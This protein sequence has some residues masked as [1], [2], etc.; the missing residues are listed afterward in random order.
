MDSKRCGA[1]SKKLTIVSSFSCK[2]DNNYCAIHRI[3][4]NH[5]CSHISMFKQ[6]GIDKLQKQL[7]KVVNQKVPV[8]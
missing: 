1:C 2:C 3:P 6:D 4:E 5:E 7:I 8:C